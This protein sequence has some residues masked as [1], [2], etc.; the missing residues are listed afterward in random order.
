MNPATAHDWPK[1]A[2]WALMAIPLLAYCAVVYRY[3]V[4]IPFY[5]DITQILWI[6]NTIIDVKLDSPWVTEVDRPSTLKAFFYPNAGHI[7][8][9]TRLFTLL[10]YQLGGVNFRISIMV[11]NAGWIASVALM[12]WYARKRLDLPWPALLPVPFLMLG[13]SHWESL[14]F[15]L[16][17]WQMYWGAALFPI[18]MLLAMVHGRTLVAMVCL[19]GALFTSGGSLALFPVAAAFLLWRRHWWQLAMFAIVGGLML[20]LFLYFNPPGY[21]LKT[22][23]DIPAMIRYTT[24]FM[25]NLLSTGTW[26]MSAYATVH[27]VTGAII[28]LLF[29][30]LFFTTRGPEFD[31]P[32]MVVAYVILLGGMAAYKRGNTEPDMVS[33][34]SMF[35]LMAAVSTYYLLLAYL[36]ERKPLLSHVAAVVIAVTA[37]G[38]WVHT[39]SVDLAP[40]NQNRSQRIDALN[41]YLQTGNAGGLMWHPEW[42][43][44]IF[45][46][47]KRIGI[48]DASSAAGLVPYSR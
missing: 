25:G 16:P 22:T 48:Y 6:T 18:A 14:D 34:Y 40:L 15:T 12:L 1:R 39:Y 30:I 38:F 42:A 9:L 21:H 3:A 47:A 35:A 13:L 23:P 36:R 20:W 37:L 28:L 2:T 46:E 26:D 44:E 4:N 45:R 43:D 24:A 19:F 10:Q 41:T 32:K 17:A 11:A 7:P 27:T 29:T 5:D 8:L 31:F 33:R